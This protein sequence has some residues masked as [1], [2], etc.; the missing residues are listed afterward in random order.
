M[1]EALEVPNCLEVVTRYFESAARVVG[2]EGKMGALIRNTDREL[3]VEVPVRMDDGRLEVFN[4]YRI[5]HNNARGPY[6]GGV[7]YHPKVDAQEVTALAA[8][9]TWKT[10]LV[11]VPF[12]G[13]KG[14][15]TVDPGQLSKFEL[16]R[17]TRR[18]INL[19]EP[20]IGPNEDIPA[21]DVNTNAQT[22]AWMMD[23][24]SRSHGYTPAIVTGKPPSV[25]GSQGRQEAT[26]LGVAIVTGAMCERIGLKLQGAR[27]VIQG[28]GNVG[29]NTARFLHER[30]AKIV[31]ISDVH[32]GKYHPLGLD[33]PQAL[34]LQENEGSIRLLDRAEDCTNAE[35]L[36]LDCEVL[37]PAALDCVVTADNAE[38]IKARLVVEAANAPTTFEGDVLLAARGVP[39]VPDILANA[40]GVTVSYFEWVQNLQQLYWSREQVY[41]QLEMI[42]LRAFEAAQATAAKQHTTLRKA[43]YILALER[44]TEATRVRG[45]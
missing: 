6:K 2:L 43:A 26:G 30:G 7:R 41:S 25:G 14:G 24:Y 42:M 9:M 38:R 3:R 10:A 39:V 23:E 17:L 37:I 12:G 28:F 20:I 16:E 31:A 19:I 27:V 8:L 21:P 11:D 4:G 32:G 22:M 40:G 34:R 45:V 1:N 13:A 44:V 15:I 36:E 18:F 35:L 29:S 33:I 5:Q